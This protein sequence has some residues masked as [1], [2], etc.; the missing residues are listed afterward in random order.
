MKR[1]FKDIPTTTV[2]I[3]FSNQVWRNHHAT[4]KKMKPNSD[5]IHTGSILGLVKVLHSAIAH[6]TRH[7]GDAKLVICEDRPPERKRRLYEKYQEVFSEYEGVQRYKG[8]RKPRDL[9]YNPVEICKEFISCIPHTK[10]Y[11]DREEADDVMAA[12]VK[13][14][15]NDPTL[16]Y[17]SDRDMW[18]LWKLYKK[19]TII[20]GE[21]E[22]V[23]ATAMMKRFDTSD[24]NKVVLHK[25]LRDD[26]G[27]NVKGIRNW[28]F[29]MTKEAFDRCD[30]S[31]ESYFRHL[32]DIFGVDHRYVQ[33][34]V[35]QSGI[36]ML[37]RKL[38]K[39]RC[40]LDYTVRVIKDYNLDKW[41]YL[42]GTFETE[43]IRK[44]PILK[45]F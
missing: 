29:K 35:D 15:P 13:D 42:C 34:L 33:R 39:L 10:I 21:N 28:P 45:L 12:W 26:G 4:E 8:N 11:C 9:D 3:D 16:M 36:V 2:L 23:D 1:K 18:Q 37:N 31:I 43:S 24:P 40:N 19:L 41:E 44:S 14:H 30:G 32:V 5:G 38:V 27:D 20:Y 17:S 7:G 6:L 25:M 22:S